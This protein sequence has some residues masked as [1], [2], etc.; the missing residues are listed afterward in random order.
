MNWLCGRSYSCAGGSISCTQDTGGCTDG[1]GGA[2]GGGWGAGGAVG[3]PS[4][5]F[6]YI[7]KCAA[8]VLF[9]AYIC[10]QVR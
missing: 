1:A 8:D 4:A 9:L 10:L 7:I 3:P 5:M 2:T 6:N